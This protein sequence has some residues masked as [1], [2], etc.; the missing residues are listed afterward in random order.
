MAG[1]GCVA[2]HKDVGSRVMWQSTL[3]MLA[4][5]YAVSITL[6]G[7]TEDEGKYRPV[8]TNFE[9]LIPDSLK[10]L[11]EYPGNPQNLLPDNQAVVAGNTSVSIGRLSIA[12]RRRSLAD[13]VTRAISP[14]SPGHETGDH[15]RAWSCI[16]AS[17]INGQD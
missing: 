11:L 4:H 17:R 6:I 2:F 14:M 10:V 8:P 15:R 7:G 1:V 3:A 12:W 13:S 9:Q 5:G 16:R